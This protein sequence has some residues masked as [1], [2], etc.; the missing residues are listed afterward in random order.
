MHVQR[1]RVLQRVEHGD[2]AEPGVGEVGHAGGG[3]HS[4][5][6]PAPL[7]TLQGAT[8][9]SSELGA[10]RVVKDWIDG[11]KNVNQ[12]GYLITTTST[13]NQTTDSGTTTT[14]YD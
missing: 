12:R 1:F 5:H 3:V 13:P 11:T 10:Q 9:R 8:K 6:H 4:P 7:P 14:Y 2:G